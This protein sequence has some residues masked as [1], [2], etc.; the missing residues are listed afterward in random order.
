MK[1]STIRFSIS[2]GG[3]F[4]WVNSFE[5]RGRY[6]FHAGSSILTMDFNTKELR[7]TV[8]EQSTLLA[9]LDLKLAPLRIKG[10]EGNVTLK[11]GS[12]IDLRTDSLLDFCFLVSAPGQDDW[13]FAIRPESLS[14]DGRLLLEHNGLSLSA[15][16]LNSYWN[17]RATNVV[18][19]E[20]TNSNCSL[21]KTLG[22][23]IWHLLFDYQ[24]TD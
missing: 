20:C 4:R 16:N 14:A 5:L 2:N 1:N 17:S 10:F 15:P 12:S 3:G 22:V 11:D 24:L 9:R 13:A 7:V 23:L 18:E 19:V 8:R 6:N 21:A